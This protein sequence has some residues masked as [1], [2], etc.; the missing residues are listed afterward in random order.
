MEIRTQKSTCDKRACRRHITIESSFS[1]SVLGETF[2][3]ENNSHHPTACNYLFCV[4]HNV[5][6][7]GDLNKDV[8]LY[9]TVV[10]YTTNKIGVF[11]Q[12]GSEFC[13]TVVSY[14]TVD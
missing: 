9:V 2:K 1:R 8:R 14:N 11:F 7:T 13:D 10:N 4:S 5:I 6:A 3:N 12:N